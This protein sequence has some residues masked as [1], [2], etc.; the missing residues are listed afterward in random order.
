MGRSRG[1]YCTDLEP[2]ASDLHT[3]HGLTF[4]PLGQAPG[5]STGG[6]YYKICVIL[7]FL[8]AALPWLLVV[9]PI[10]TNANS[11]VK[12]MMLAVSLLVSVLRQTNF[13]APTLLLSLKNYFPRSVK[14]LL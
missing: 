6:F 4:C 2:C 8:I 9:G 10:N 13:Q 12:N 14:L 11:V 5:V 1:Y 7:I 3:P